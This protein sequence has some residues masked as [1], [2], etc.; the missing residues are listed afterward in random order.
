MGRRCGMG[1]DEQL[2][3]GVQSLAGQCGG[4]I[5]AA[6][7]GVGSTPRTQGGG[8]EISVPTLRADA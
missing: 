2:G 5:P 4:E 7:G 3:H 8:R 6:A 1:K